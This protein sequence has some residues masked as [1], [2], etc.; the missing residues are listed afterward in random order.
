MKRI[1]EAEAGLRMDELE[2]KV[3]SFLILHQKDTIELTDLSELAF[4]NLKKYF[5]GK[6]DVQGII[7]VLRT[8]SSEINYTL[9]ISKIQE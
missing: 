4:T 2:K 1:T 5:D 9:H 7:T 8:G 6:Y 3:S